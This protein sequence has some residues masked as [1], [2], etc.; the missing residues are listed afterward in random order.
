M[1]R[2]FIYLMI[3]G[4]GFG[5]EDKLDINNPNEPSVQYFWQ[6]EE[7]AVKGV[8]AVYSTL[9]KGSISRWMPMLFSTRSDIGESRS[10]WTDLA[11]ALDKFIQ[12]DYNFGPV[13]GVW[14]DNYVG[15]NRANQVLDNVPDIAMDTDKKNEVLGQAYFFRGLFYYHL[16]TL[17]GNV[18]LMLKT[19]SP[20]DY[21]ANSSVEEVYGQIIADLEKAVEMLPAKY[22]SPEDLGR[23]TKG[24]AHALMA[25]AYFQLKD[26]QNALPSLEWLV[27]GEGGDLYDLVP[28]YRDNF[29]VTTENNVE[30]V[31]EWQFA[32][33]PNEFTDDDIATPNHNYGSSMAQ[34]TAPV[35]IGWSDAE[36]RRWIIYEF[37]ELTVAGDRDPR[38]E[39]SFLFDSTHIN[40]PDETLVYG[41][42]FSSRYG[43]GPD[44]KRVWVRKFLNDHWKIEEGYRSPNNYR[45]I[46]YADVLLM[47]A[48][49]LNALNRTAEAYPH[50]DRVRQ[51]ASLAPLSTVMPGL[52]QTAFLEQLKKERLLELAGEGHRWNDLMRWGDIGP[53]LSVN[54][55]AFNN[56]EV[57]K[58]ELLPIPQVDRD[59]NP[60]LDQNPNW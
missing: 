34:F 22:A 14:H 10:P 54:D 16:V 59:V 41:V 3:I 8:N 58:H 5:C 26:Y 57:G 12:P 1:K 37:D 28:N 53:Q 51:R 35:G 31:F 39:A 43:T 23:V 52:G 4:L 60:N 2:I 33:N 13:A 21:P 38:V 30:S 40:G 6:N 20:D 46:R 17:F 44:S 19:T 56:F 32:E 18:P 29:L 47:Y 27:D 7:D 55:P 49:C 9:H 48:E 15:I 50:V 24:A 11:N 36:A 25:K 42:S 45:Y